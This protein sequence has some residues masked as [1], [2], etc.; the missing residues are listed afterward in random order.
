MGLIFIGFLV[1]AHAVEALPPFNDESLHIRRAEKILIERNVSLTIS[2][3]LI[4][5]WIA[6]FR[7]DQIHAI[8]IGRTAVAL[9]STIGLA[10][11]FATARLLFG[12]IAGYFALLLA[13]FSPFMIFFDRFVFADPLSAAL[14]I[15]VL[16]MS[17]R[18]V[19]RQPCVTGRCSEALMAGILITLVILAK[20]TSLPFL[21][22][23][24]VAVFAF[25]NGDKPI[26][27][28]LR[29][30]VAWVLQRLKA[31]LKPLRTVYV[32]F[33]ITF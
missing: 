29:Q 9:F 19:R 22:M 32:V 10:G 21:G 28:R 2:K 26:S 14:A 7:P 8:F 33:A 27:F 3:L 12:R 1:R 18:L 5:Y 20:I 13:A 25:G 31:Y 4:Y 11:T 6:F 24:I 16:W 17:V 15:L 30:L 23:P